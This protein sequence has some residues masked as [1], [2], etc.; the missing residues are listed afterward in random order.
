MKTRVTW[1]RLSLLALLCWLNWPQTAAA[2]A[3]CFGKSD[4]KLAEGLNMGIFA[5]L[6]LVLLVLGWLAG[7]FIYLSRRAA[8][9]ARV[10]ES[11][12][13]ASHSPQP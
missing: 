13:S 1:A 8:A 3:T 9:E 5:L 6:G 7:F 2:C 10:V 4:S 12:V 11:A